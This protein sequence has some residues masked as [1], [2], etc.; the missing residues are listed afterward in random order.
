MIELISFFLASILSAFAISAV[1]IIVIRKILQRYMSSIYAVSDESGLEILEEIEVGG[2]K[3]WLH[4]RGRCRD[5]PILL[6]VHGGP[7]ASHIGWF[8]AIQRPWENHFTVAQWDQRQ[9]GKSYTKGI[10]NT[11]SHRQYIDDAEQMIAYLRQRFSKDK[12]FLMGTSYGT[13]LSMQ[14]VSRCPDWLYAYVAVGQVVKMK[15]HAIEEYRLLLELSKEKGEEELES[16]LESLAPF[17]NPTDPVNSYMNNAVRFMEE[18]SK[19]GKCFPGGFIEMVNIVTLSKWLSPHYTLKDHYNRL[20][21]DTP[22]PADKENPFYNEFFDYDIPSEI[23]STFKVPIFFFTGSDDFHVA[24]TLTNKWF[25]A[26]E[27]PYKEQIWFEQSAHAPHITEP[28]KFAQ[29][30]IEKVRP[31]HEINRVNSTIEKAVSEV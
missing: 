14:L 2:T 9:T 27:A 29:S 30:L 18:E 21:G 11:I 7:G 6:F 20:F 28:Y 19:L 26:I 13:Y 17:P 10:G 12:I 31:F 15:E 3:Q 24:Y 22:A 23:G 5:N 1:I 8:D 25:E 16:Y 4:V